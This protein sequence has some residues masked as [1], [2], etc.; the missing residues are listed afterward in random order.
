V[1]PANGNGDLLPDERG[2]PIAIKALS[3]YPSQPHTP[4]AIDGDIK[5]RWSGGVQQSSA[6]FTI[7]IA[8]PGPVSQVVIDLG[9]FWT[10]FPMRVRIEASPDGARWDTVY[11][12][13]TALHAYYAAVRH[14]KQ[15]PVVYPIGR[16]HVRF[17]RFTQLGWGTHDWSIPELRVLR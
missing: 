15:V 1:L 10:D 13:D 8:D 11:A 6:D 2:T 16:D 12:G 4:R 3:A 5:T 9:E 7:E 14:P 17:I